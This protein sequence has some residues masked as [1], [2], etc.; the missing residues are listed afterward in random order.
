MT[1]E[2][3][4]RITRSSEPEELDKE[5]TITLQKPADHIYPAYDHDLDYEFD[6]IRSIN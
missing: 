2:N 1:Q 6:A 5:V 3:S 4:K